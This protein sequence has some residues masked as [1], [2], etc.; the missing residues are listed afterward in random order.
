[1][2][3][4]LK[5]RDIAAILSPVTVIAYENI[6][7]QLLLLREILTKEYITRNDK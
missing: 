1:M 3:S 5:E 2:L 4:V 7:Q 6:S